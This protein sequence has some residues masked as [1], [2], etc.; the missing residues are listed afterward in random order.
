MTA[1][2]INKIAFN[3]LGKDIYWYSIILAVA[4]VT[5]F[6]LCCHRGKKMGYK[7]DTFIDLCFVILIPGIIGARILFVLTNWSSYSNDLLSVFYIWEGGLAILGGFI[8]AIPCYIIY[9]VKKKINFWE[10]MDIIAPCFALAQSIGRWGNFVNQEL[11]GPVVTNTALQF[12]PISVFID[13]TNSW[14]LATFFYESVWSLMTFIVLTLLSRKKHEKGDIFLL[15]ITFYSV[16]RIIL[17]GVKIAGTL[18]NQLICVGMIV[19]VAIAYIIK[20]RM[21]INKAFS[22]KVHSKINNK[23]LWDYS[24]EPQIKT[25]DIKNKDDKNI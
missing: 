19:L 17:D 3:I 12:F 2:S 8:T 9:C 23:L 1:L 16:I 11:Y 10:L 22:D 4:V 13:N 15:Y 24:P 14:H 7:E 20:R 6:L 25:D 18:T 5:V 21:L